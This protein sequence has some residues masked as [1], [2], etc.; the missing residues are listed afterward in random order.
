MEA[1]ASVDPGRPVEHTGQWLKGRSGGL[2]CSGMAK[3][4]G[5]TC[6]VPDPQCILGID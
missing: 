3:M 4:D 5:Q 6:L 2:R 1:L